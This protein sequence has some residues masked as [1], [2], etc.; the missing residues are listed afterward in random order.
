MSEDLE[1]YISGW[2]FFFATVGSWT[3]VCDGF[4]ALKGSFE[5]F[6]VILVIQVFFVLFICALLWE[7]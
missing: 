6:E 4:A 5:M 7:D 2:A 3:W 1:W